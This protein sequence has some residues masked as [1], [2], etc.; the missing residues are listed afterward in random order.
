M[1]SDRRGFRSRGRGSWSG[2][3]RP[4]PLHPRDDVDDEVERE[5]GD[6]DEVPVDGGAADVEVLLLRA[7]PAGAVEGDEPALA[8]RGDDVEEVEPEDHPDHRAVG[9][10]APLVAEVRE[11]SVAAEEDGE[12]GEGGGGESD[13]YRCFLLTFGGEVRP[14]YRR[15][16]DDQDQ[17]VERRPEER[18]RLYGGRRPV[19]VDGAEVEVAGDDEGEH[20]ALDDHHAEVAPPDQ[21]TAVDRSLGELADVDD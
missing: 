21:R 18:R 15:D 5:P 17:K 10:I 13:Q 6:D 12:T 19:D 14:E 1:R 8:R 16:A 20:G 3:R 2:S 9:V 7:R 4:L 11:D